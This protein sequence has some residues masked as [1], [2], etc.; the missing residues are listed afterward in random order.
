MINEDIAKELSKITRMREESPA[1]APEEISTTP[2]YI[3]SKKYKSN[4]LMDIP[5]SNGVVHEEIPPR[6]KW[7]DASASHGVFDGIKIRKKPGRK[8]K[9]ARIENG[10]SHNQTKLIIPKKPRRIVVEASNGASH[11]TPPAGVQSPNGSSRSKRTKRKALREDEYEYGEELG[12]PVISQRSRS[13]DYSDSGAVHKRQSLHPSTL[14]HQTRLSHEFQYCKQITMFW[15]ENDKMNKPLSTKDEEFVGELMRWCRQSWLQLLQENHSEE[16]R[17]L[18]ATRGLVEQALGDTLE[19]DLKPLLRTAICPPP[20]EV[21]RA[22]DRLGKTMDAL[23]PRGV[24]DDKFHSQLRRTFVEDSDDKEGYVNKLNIECKKN[25]L[26]EY[27]ALDPE[28]RALLAKEIAKELS[29]KNAKKARSSQAAPSG[30]PQTLG[31]R[32]RYYHDLWEEEDFVARQ[33]AVGKAMKPLTDWSALLA[34]YSDSHDGYYREW[35]VLNQNVHI[36]ESDF[37]FSPPLVPAHAQ[38]P[39]SWGLDARCSS[40]PL[41]VTTTHPAACSTTVLRTPGSAAAASSQDLD[42]LDVEYERLKFQLMR[43]EMLSFLRLQHLAASAAHD[44][45]LN[46]IKDKCQKIEQNLVVL[47]NMIK[48]SRRPSAPRSSRNEAADNPSI[49][50][51]ALRVRAT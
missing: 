3:R 15:S 2:T 42:D 7:A 30:V 38:H 40:S 31:K 22:S 4:G 50:N 46:P 27:V 29:G 19:V 47:N 35:S 25:A 6:P 39:A 12:G 8:P 32:G 17:G 26:P 10:N 14:A 36:S 43:Q 49:T 16:L 11:A 33:P 5:Y 28:L 21:G 48:N 1:V 45:V 44:G 24:A 34:D 37:I 9:H 51:N 13:A 20:L 18:E 41:D 23:C